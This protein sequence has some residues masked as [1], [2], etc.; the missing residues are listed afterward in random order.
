MSGNY[1]C[2]NNGTYGTKGVAN[3]ANV[4]GGR[5]KSATWTDVAGNLWLFG[6]VGFDNVTGAIGSLNDLWKFDGSTWTWVSGNYSRNNNGTYGTKGVTN[7]ANVPGG[8][9]GCATWT[10][11]VGN[12]WLFGGLGYDNV[13][14]ATGFLNDLWRFN[15]SDS[16]WTWMSGNYSCNNRGTYGTKGVANATNIPGG[17]YESVYWTDSPGNF[18]LFGGNGY[19]NISGSSGKFNDLWRFN[20]SDS[21]W[22]WMSGNYSCNNNGTYGMK[23]VANATNMPGGRI[24]SATWMDLAGNFWLFGGNGYDNVTGAN[25]YLNDLWRFNISDSTWTWMSGNYFCNNNGTYGTKGVADAANI[26]GGR[27][28]CATWTDAAGNFWLFGGYGYEKISGTSG[29]LN[30]LWKYSP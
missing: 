25:G 27:S 2:N 15:I 29:Y 22:T 3:A 1:S 18:W 12:F 23:G 24:A 20:I 10:D 6:G 14:G 21:T 26:P 16:T 4:P 11:A 28:R 19:D 30:D 5:Y 17:K 9:Y 13:T 7:V 8:R